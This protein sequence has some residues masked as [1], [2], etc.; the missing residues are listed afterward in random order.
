MK[1]LFAKSI[2]SLY[3]IVNKGDNSSI[4]LSRFAFSSAEEG[5]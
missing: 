4:T 2:L 5:L 3:F 1:I